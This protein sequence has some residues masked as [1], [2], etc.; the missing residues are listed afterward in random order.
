MRNFFLLLGFGLGLS[1]GGVLA[2]RRYSE[3]LGERWLKKAA[4]A[5]MQPA[6][7]A[8]ASSPADQRAGGCRLNVLSGLPV[9][10]ET[11][12]RMMEQMQVLLRIRELLAEGLFWKGQERRRVGWV[13]GGLWGGEKV[14]TIDR[15]RKWPRHRFCA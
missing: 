2:G 7:I 1:E 6:R 11:T 10:K 8:A 9:R 3:N 5:G 4:V 14:P 15:L 12:R 13:M